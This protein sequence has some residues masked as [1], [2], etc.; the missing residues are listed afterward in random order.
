[1]NAP[2]K[3]EDRFH[4]LIHQNHMW[5]L[6]E[7][8]SQMTPQP[9]PEAVP[10]QGKWALLKEVVTARLSI[11]RR[12]MRKATTFWWRDSIRSIRQIQR[13]MIRS[14]PTGSLRRRS[15]VDHLR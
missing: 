2:V 4:Q 8:A 5:G 11:G 6:W 9:R 3:S 13:W 1:M 14:G 12:R 7:I 15:P 10:Y